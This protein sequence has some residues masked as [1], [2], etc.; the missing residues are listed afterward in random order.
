MSVAEPFTFSFD[1]PGVLFCFDYISPY[2]YLAA[3]QVPG[4]A[5]RLG[6]PVHWMPVD[7][8]RLLQ[9]AG[10]PPPATIRNKA[11]YLL[12]D[13]KRWADHLD[14][15]F[16]MILPDA[17][18]SRPA[19]HATLALEDDD[20][21]RFARAIFHGLWSGAV[22]YH[23]KDWLEQAVAQSGMPA[24]WARPDAVATLRIRLRESTTALHRAGAFG[25]PTFILQPASG[26]RQLFWGVDRIE[27]LLR[28]AER[29]A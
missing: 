26:R 12:R 9:L 14:V 1:R 7:L 13:L 20:R 2:S 5:Q 18:D 6:I 27:F 11:R 23:E 3:T 21:A 22:D 4:L 10:N 19:L 16:R 8:P 15:P 24:A 25:V 29:I 28:A 17:F